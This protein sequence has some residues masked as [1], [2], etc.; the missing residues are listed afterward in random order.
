[1]MFKIGIEMLIAYIWSELVSDASLTFT[2]SW[3]L[4]MANKYQP[5][6]EEMFDSDNELKPEEAREDDEGDYAGLACFFVLVQIL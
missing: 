6:R 4:S 1:M 5:I 2:S 3:D